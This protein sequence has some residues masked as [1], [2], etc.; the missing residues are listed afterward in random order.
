MK[1][2]IPARL[3]ASAALLALT[4]GV[5]LMT[6]P[7]ASAA[8]EPS[9]CT[10]RFGDHAGTITA[11]AINVRSGPSTSYAS[12]GYLYR[13]DNI[14]LKCGRGDWYYGTLTARSK[15]GL[16]AY[17]SGWVHERFLAQLA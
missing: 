16:P 10:K 14:K 11:N 17:T 12:K 8:S 2:R 7:A 15:S 9:S 6:A 3:A 13:S 1:L 4:T 5:G